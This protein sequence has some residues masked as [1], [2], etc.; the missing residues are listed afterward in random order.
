MLDHRSLTNRTLLMTYRTVVEAKFPWHRGTLK[1][2][3]RIKTELNCI[4]H[5]RSE[6]SPASATCSG[7]GASLAIGAAA[8]P[9]AGAGAVDAGGLARS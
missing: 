6:R 3:S 4:R 2:I 8:L 1:K 5:R 9:F 7:V